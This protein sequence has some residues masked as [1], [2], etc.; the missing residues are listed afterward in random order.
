MAWKEDRQKIERF[1]SVY[2]EKQEELSKEKQKT[3]P[4]ET[5]LK[6]LLSVMNVSFRQ[7]L[8]V[9]E[10]ITESCKYPVY[11]DFD[12]KIKKELS[13]LC[14]ETAKIHAQRKAN[15]LMQK[16]QK[17]RQEIS[18]IRKKQRIGISRFKLIRQIKKQA[19]LF[20]HMIPKEKK[21][22]KIRGTRI[23]I[24]SHRPK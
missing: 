5:K 22:K 10:R 15:E 14:T 21:P 4:D 17:A 18:R 1:L 3:N 2:R 23:I 16:Q 24:I 11:F 20:P 12:R 6:K 9:S 19:G 13:G 7:A 8:K